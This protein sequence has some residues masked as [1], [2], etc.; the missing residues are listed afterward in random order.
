MHAQVAVYSPYAG[1]L[2]AHGMLEAEQR[3][4]G[5]RKGSE[6]GYDGYCE[7][8]GTGLNRSSVDYGCR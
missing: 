6:V 7:Q 1:Y 8:A 5:G 3:D 4:G 2:D